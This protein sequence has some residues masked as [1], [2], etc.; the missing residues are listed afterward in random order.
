MLNASWRELSGDA[1]CMTGEPVTRLAVCM[2]GQHFLGSDVCMTKWE[3]CFAGAG[4]MKWNHLLG[5]AA[6]ELGG[7]GTF[8][9]K[10]LLAR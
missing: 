2:T 10:M 1:V 6:S 3:H 5:N 9:G 8:V 4:H 7:G